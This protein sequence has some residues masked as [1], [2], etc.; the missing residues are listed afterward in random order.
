MNRRFTFLVLIFA[1]V[2]LLPFRSPAPLVH[3]PGEG[4]YY[5]PVGGDMKW[6]RNRASEQLQ[7]A[8]DALKKKDYSIALHSAHRIL[9]IWPMSDYAPAAQFIIGEC[10]EAT[11]KDELAFNAYQTLVQKYPKSEEYNTALKQEYEIGNRFLNGEWTRVLYGFIPFPMMMD[12]T[13]KMFE[14]I[15]ENGPYSDIAP[16]AQLQVGAAY[17]KHGSY[18]EAVKA[19][20]TAADRYHDQP[21]IAAD[22]MYHEGQ[23]YEKQAAHAEYDQSTAGKAIAA[24][25]DFST[26]YPDDKRVAD[27]QKAIAVL[28]AEQ[29]RGNFEIAKFYEKGHKWMGAVIYYNEVLQLDPNSPYAATARQRIEILKPRIKT[30]ESAS[31]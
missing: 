1:F 22:A 2:A 4:W 11:G 31:N 21:A 15:V 28:K 16:H 24:Y 29:V 12:D 25:T 17:D 7:V 8:Q 20:Q 13:A 30:M 3:V 27:A 18:E 6:V 5:E 19:Y 26:L 10:L 14:K 23:S 9:R